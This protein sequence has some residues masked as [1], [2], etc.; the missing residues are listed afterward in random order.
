MIGWMKKDTGILTI[1]KLVYKRTYCMLLLTGLVTII[2]SDRVS[3]P[4]Q[5][6][7]LRQLNPLQRGKKSKMSHL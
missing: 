2:V 5:A 7:R 6:P 4:D 3:S 1:S